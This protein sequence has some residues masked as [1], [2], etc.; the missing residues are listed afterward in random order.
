MLSLSMLRNE[1]RLRLL[2][3]LLRSGKRVQ[4]QSIRCVGTGSLTVAN[5]G[6]FIG[7]PSRVYAPKRSVRFFATGTDKESC[8]ASGTS[9]TDTA[10]TDLVM[11][12]FLAQDH[13]LSKINSESQL[14]AAT[15]SPTVL[16]SMIDE[17]TK[18]YKVV[19][20]KTVSILVEQAVRAGS[21]SK[22]ALERLIHFHVKAGNIIDAAYILSKCD[23]AVLP[24]SATV[25]NALTTALVE[26]GNWNLAFD[27]CKYMIQLDYQFAGSHIFFTVGGLMKDSESVEKALELLK[28]ITTKRRTDLAEFFSYTKV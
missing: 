21:S 18:N 9:A 2:D 10:L 6:T 16:S 27:M 5:G 14:L 4:L 24:I 12:K 22:P 3:E 23:P 20:H 26:N 17:V 25:S 11:G 13:Y 7:A 19:D 8:H 15:L 28:L 1:A